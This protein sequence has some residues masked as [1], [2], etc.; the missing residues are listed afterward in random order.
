M[1]YKYKEVF[2]RQFSKA[3]GK[4]IPT[5]CLEKPFLHFLRWKVFSI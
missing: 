1:P 4:Y 3:N 5:Y 2:L